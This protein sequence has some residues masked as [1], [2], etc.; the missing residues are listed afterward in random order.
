MLRHELSR[1]KVRLLLGVL[2]LEDAARN[3]YAVPGV[4]QLVGHESQHFADDRNKAL[5]DQLAH[6]LGVAHAL[7]APH[8]NVHSSLAYLLSDPP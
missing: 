1:P 6:L 7:V 8:R 4:D 3:D 2:M 5:I